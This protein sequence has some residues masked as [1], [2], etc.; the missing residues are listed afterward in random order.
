MQDLFSHRIQYKD[1]AK[2]RKAIKENYRSFGNLFEAYRKGE[3][4]Q[5]NAV[6]LA[7]DLHPLITKGLIDFVNDSARFR[8]CNITFSTQKP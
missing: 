4:A 1:S 6:M 8:Y 2:L 5:I 3:I 7:K